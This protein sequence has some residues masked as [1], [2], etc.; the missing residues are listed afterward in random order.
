MAENEEK[1]AIIIDHLKSRY[2]AEVLIVVGSRAVGDFKPRSDWD[3]C[4][5]TDVD[6]HP[7]ESFQEAV[8]AYPAT[9]KDE[10]IDLYWN[11]MD[12]DSYSPKLWR[13]LRNSKVVLDTPDGFGIKLR[14]KAIELYKKG[15]GK[16]GKAP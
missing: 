10:D 6:V 12:I 9:I 4:L 15:P 1:L 7:N 8:E 14:E 11:S 16:R 2:E 3:I 13:D 5:F